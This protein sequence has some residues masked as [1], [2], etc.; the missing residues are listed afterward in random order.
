MAPEQLRGERADQRSDIFAFGAI[1]HEMLSGELA[2]KRDTPVET[3]NAILNEEPRALTGSVP[4]ELNQLIGRCLEKIS[5]DRFQSAHDIGAKLVTIRPATPAARL[6]FAELKRRRVFR[7]LVAYGIAT[8][9]ILQIIEPIMHGLHWPDAV[10]SHVVVALALGFPIVVGLAWVFDVNGGRIE[11][12]TS[13]GAIRQPRLAMVLVGIGVLAAAPGTVWYFLV[14][15]ITRPAAAEDRRSIAVLPF[16]SLNTGEE[17]AYFADGI[18]GDLLTQLSKIG[19][20][21]VIS[22]TSV[23]QYRTGARNLREIGEALGVA[24]VLEGSVQRAGNRVRIEARLSDVR[25]DRQ[26]WAERYDR[27]LTD[28]FAIQSAVTEEIARA[29]N[30]RPSPG[31]KG[32]IETQTY[33]EH[34]GL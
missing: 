31:E 13:A 27:E 20:L 8:F 33:Q 16:A 26:I 15:G 18:H 2:F 5:N 24:T 29:L 21:K 25:D 6:I 22:R 1:L 32:R 23:L 30:A 7:A 19:D 28:V 14:R 12:A 4:V 3:G 34:R 11:R 17:N 10:L 9:A